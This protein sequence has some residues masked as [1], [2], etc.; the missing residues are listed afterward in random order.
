[1]F[2]SRKRKSGSNKDARKKYPDEFKTVVLNHFKDKREEGKTPNQKECQEFLENLPEFY[3]GTA[4]ISNVTW[5][6][7]KDLVHNNPVKKRKRK[8]KMEKAKQNKKQ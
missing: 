2:H 8:P 3:A 4:L 5:R 7:V 1:M 6:M